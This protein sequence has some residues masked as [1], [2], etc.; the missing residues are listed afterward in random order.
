MPH[1]HEV[2]GSSPGGSNMRGHSSMVE[3]EVSSNLV[4]AF[5]IIATNNEETVKD[6]YGP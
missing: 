1:K 2:P 5:L 4:V 3:H 6:T